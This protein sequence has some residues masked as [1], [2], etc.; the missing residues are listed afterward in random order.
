[1]NNHFWKVALLRVYCYGKQD[2]RTNFR[3]QIYCASPNQS[4]RYRLRPVLD[5]LAAWWLNFC[6]FK[7]ALVNTDIVKLQNLISYALSSF[8][9]IFYPIKY[10][11]KQSTVFKY[12]S[13]ILIRFSKLFTNDIVH[14][15]CKKKPRKKAAP[16]RLILLRLYCLVQRHCFLTCPRPGM[17]QAATVVA[18]TSYN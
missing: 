9:V 6:R 14:N 7:N 11:Q 17:W 13:T 2:I 15:K 5:C 16:L 10:I 12:T 8:V 18:E 1:M 3:G 4:L